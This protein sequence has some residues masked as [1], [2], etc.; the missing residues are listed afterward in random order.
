MIVWSIWYTRSLSLAL[1]VKAFYTR[2]MTAPTLILRHWQF[3]SEQGAITPVLPDGCRDLIVKTDARGEPLWFVS[4]L[5]CTTQQ[6]TCVAAQKFKGFRFHPAVQI[7]ETNLLAAFEACDGRESK[8][9]L[10][11]RL[12][13]FVYLD[14][15]LAEALE[16]LADNRRKVDTARQLGVSE[17]TLER[18]VKKTTGQRP[19]FWKSLARTRRTARQ[20]LSGPPLAALAADNGYAD[21]AH[22]TREFRKWFGATPRQFTRDN[23]LMALVQASGYE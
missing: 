8:Q 9:Q 4:P 1:L 6:V 18:L 13:E 15:D 3:M 7:D 2:I 11:A 23:Q 20:L 5:A 12:E 10:V 17:R 21:Q 14:S 19:L 16:A 22:M